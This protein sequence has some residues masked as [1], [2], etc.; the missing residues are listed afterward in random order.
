M[1]T[2]F[3]TMYEL[4]TKYGGSMLEAARAGDWAA[5]EKGLELNA[6]SHDEEGDT[7]ITPGNVGMLRYYARQSDKGKRLFKR[8]GIPLERDQEED[9]RVGGRVFGY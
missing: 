4:Y 7:L 6:Q 5:V 1:G 2:M 9:L 3:D 8:W